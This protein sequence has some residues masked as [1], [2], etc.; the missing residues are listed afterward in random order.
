[1]TKARDDPYAAAVEAIYGAAFAPMRWPDALTAIAD[2]FGDVGALLMYQRDDSSLATVVSPG[3]EKA[4]RDYQ[5]GEW[6]R[7]DIGM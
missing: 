1:M 2:I 3:L 6:W 4:Q 5:E 7:H